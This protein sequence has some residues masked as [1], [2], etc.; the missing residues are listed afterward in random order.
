[1]EVVF[2]LHIQVEAF[3]HILPDPHHS[4]DLIK[5]TACTFINPR[6]IFLH[7]CLQTIALALLNFQIQKTSHALL[8]SYHLNL[9][10]FWI[11]LHTHYYLKRTYSWK[12]MRIDWS[13]L[14]SL[15]LLW[16]LFIR[17]P[18]SIYR[19]STSFTAT[20][21]PCPFSSSPSQILHLALRLEGYSN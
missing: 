3:N 7:D 20:T 2:S 15:G 14:K 10:H 17:N 13:I 21:F 19:N 1:V 12:T 6:I 8:F 5:S 18:W 9:Y 11:Y 4:M 16:M